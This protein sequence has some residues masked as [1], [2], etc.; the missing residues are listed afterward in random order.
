M[1]TN[2]NNVAVEEKYNRPCKLG[3]LFRWIQIWSKIPY[4]S[5]MPAKYTRK[6]KN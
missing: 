3:N 5:E 4:V 2:E 6:F 1:N